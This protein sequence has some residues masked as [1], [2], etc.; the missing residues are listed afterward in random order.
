MIINKEIL[1]DDHKGK[2]I[3]ADKNKCT[4]VKISSDK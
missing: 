3:L 4:Q 2:Y 1:T